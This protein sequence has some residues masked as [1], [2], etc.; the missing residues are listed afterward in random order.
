MEP[1]AHSSVARRFLRFADA[2]NLALDTL[3]DPTLAAAFEEGCASERVPATA[4]VEALQVCAERSGRPDLGAV[5]G[6]FGEVGGYGPLSLM[7]EHC[8]TIRQIVEAGVHFMH[9]ENSAL[10]LEIDEDEEEASVCYLP[11]VATRWGS[12]QFMEAILMLSLR[13]ARAFLGEQW[14]PLRVEFGHAGPGNLRA[15]R[16]LFR[17]NLKFGADR[18]AMVLSRRDLDRPAR[19]GDPERRATLE[20]RLVELD[21]A[22]SEDFSDQVERATARVLSRGSVRI[23]AVAESLG[24]Q[25]RTLQRRL[26][27][28]GMQFSHVL[29]RVRRRTALDYLLNA[30]RPTLTDLAQRLSYGDASATSRFLRSSLGLGVRGFPGDEI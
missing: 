21:R 9:L 7:P 16:R 20:M 23:G 24:M 26:A 13:G 25:A 28:D 1:T 8:T 12:A 11:M 15:H 14:A 10:A 22:S 17:A 4:I 29:E 27:D 5:F 3:L 6:T 19:A 30:H 2:E 18:Y